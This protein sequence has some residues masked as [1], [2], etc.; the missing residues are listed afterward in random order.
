MG[1]GGGFLER[2]RFRPDYR[3]GDIALQKDLQLRDGY[4]AHVT[5]I[6]GDPFGIPN[7]LRRLERLTRRQWFYDGLTADQIEEDLNF[8]IQ[9][10]KYEKYEKDAVESG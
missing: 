2:K 8:F 4:I 3:E 1:G 6:H 10:E 5:V 7:G 9:Q